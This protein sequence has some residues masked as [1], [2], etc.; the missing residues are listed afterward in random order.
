MIIKNLDGSTQIIHHQD[1]GEPKR[2]YK[3][4]EK[5]EVIIFEL[6]YI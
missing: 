2:L 5:I 6:L 1:K 3:K 4:E